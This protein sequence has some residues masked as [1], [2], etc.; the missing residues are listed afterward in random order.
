MF[1]F[2]DYTFDIDQNCSWK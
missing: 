2:T 1:D